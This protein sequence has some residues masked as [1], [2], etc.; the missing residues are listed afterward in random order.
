MSEFCP[1]QAFLNR[2][3][4]IVEL[5]SAGFPSRDDKMKCQKSMIISAI[6]DYFIDTAPQELLDALNVCED[7]V[8]GG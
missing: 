6:E 7:K 8:F 2:M 4:T 5:Q 1:K 3:Q